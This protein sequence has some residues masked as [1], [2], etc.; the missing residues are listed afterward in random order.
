MKN[1]RVSILPKR[2]EHGKH[3]DYDCCISVVPKEYEGIGPMPFILEAVK[4][5]EAD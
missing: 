2:P 1:Y 3:S 4:T 5:S